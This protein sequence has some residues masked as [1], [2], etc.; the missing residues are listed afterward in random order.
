MSNNKKIWV[1]ICRNENKSVP[2][3]YEKLH[4]NK[5]NDMS[6]RTPHGDDT[7]GWRCAEGEGPEPHT[8][9]FADRTGT[10]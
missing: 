9:D 7:G 10:V 1:I 5:T 2:L 4:F 8:G 3:Q 6:V